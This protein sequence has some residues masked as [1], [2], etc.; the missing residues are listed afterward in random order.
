M[1]SEWFTTFEPVDRRWLGEAA[2]EEEKTEDQGVRRHFL[3]KQEDFANIL[4]KF[5]GEK[6]IL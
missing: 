5:A 3:E 2:E 1:K 6:I 4:L